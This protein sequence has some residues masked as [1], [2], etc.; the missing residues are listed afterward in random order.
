MGNYQIFSVSLV[1][2]E[3]FQKY[4]SSYASL[5]N[6]PT[7][8]IIIF[9]HS[10]LLRP[11]LGLYIIGHVLLCCCIREF[12]CLCK[13]TEENKMRDLQQLS[14]DLLTLLRMTYQIT[15]KDRNLSLFMLL[16]QLDHCSAFSSMGAF[17]ALCETC[18][19]EK[20]DVIVVIFSLYICAW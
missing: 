4:S 10:D 14:L 2:H 6:F 9:V 11:F 16:F 8:I 12:I 3:I 7:V 5:H 15:P 17:L 13:R 1:I 18:F 20:L 19:F